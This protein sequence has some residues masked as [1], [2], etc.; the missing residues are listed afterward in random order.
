LN[1]GWGERFFRGGRKADFV[2]ETRRRRGRCSIGP[3]KIGMEAEGK[4]GDWR[5][6]KGRQRIGRNQQ[7]GKN[8]PASS[9]I[10]GLGG[11]GGG[12]GGR[13]ALGADQKAYLEEKEILGSEHLGLMV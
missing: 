3:P 9:Q 1:A 8:K 2:L 6:G 12:H 13:T 11:G 4:R 5:V 7:E 10:P